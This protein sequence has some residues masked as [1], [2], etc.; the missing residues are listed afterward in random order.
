MGNNQMSKVWEQMG[1]SSEQGFEG[2]ST[3]I[4][5]VKI[6][7]ITCFISNRLTSMIYGSNIQSNLSE[8]QPLNKDHP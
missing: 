8:R 1:S 2:E 7:D 4:V 5:N 3:I 6:Y